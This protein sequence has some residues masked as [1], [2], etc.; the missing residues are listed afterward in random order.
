MSS[1]E[2]SRGEKTLS[3]EGGYSGCGVLTGVAV[4]VGLT[5][6]VVG[7]LSFSCQCVHGVDAMPRSLVVVA[8]VPLLLRVRRVLCVATHVRLLG[9]V[10]GRLVRH[11]HQADILG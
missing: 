1:I 4:V 2:G 8:M 7:S 11:R 6:A 3:S 10:A 9:V 5:T